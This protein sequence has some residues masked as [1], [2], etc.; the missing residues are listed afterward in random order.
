MSLFLFSKFS[1][2]VFLYAFVVL[3]LVFWG[4]GAGVLGGGG[5]FCRQACIYL[6]DG[7]I[8][9]VSDETEHI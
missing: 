9:P 5:C 8:R 7:C 6:H 4:E 3:N 1:F 2:S